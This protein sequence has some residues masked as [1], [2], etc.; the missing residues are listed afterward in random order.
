M[1]NVRRIWVWFWL[2][3]IVASLHVAEPH[4]GSPLAFLYAQHVAG[5]NLCILPKDD[6]STCC[7]YIKHE[8]DPHYF[9]IARYYYCWSKS[10]LTLVRLGISVAILSVLSV[11]LLSLSILVSNY[12]FVNIHE[13]TL[14]LGI[15]DNILSFILIPLTNTFPDLIN[16]YVILDSGSTELVLGQ[17]LGSILIMF[18]VIFGLICIFNDQYQVHRRRVFMVDLL[19]V[20]F[21]LMVFLYILSDSQ[22]TVFECSFM[23]VGY[24]VYVGF[25]NR[26]SKP[27]VAPELE[28]VVSPPL[29]PYTFE[30][31]LSI[32]SQEE[33][34]YGAISPLS[35]DSVPKI[36]SR[37][38]SPSVKSFDDIVIEE[39]LSI[40]QTLVTCI[41][42]VFFFLVPIHMTPSNLEE[43]EWRN[44]LN[45]HSL[46]TLW[47]STTIPLLINY[48]FAHLP[49]IDMIP[50]T[51]TIILAVFV[52]AP[53]LSHK[54]MVINVMGLFCSMIVLQEISLI[55]LQ[56]LK[57]FGLVWNMSDYLLGMLIF[58]VSNSI[59]DTITNLTIATKINPILGINACLG[60]PILL[61]FLG[62]G[63]NGFVVTLKHNA[64]LKFDLNLDLIVN[65]G[66][67]LVIL[68][69]YSIYV[70]L[71]KW[72]FD[73]RLGFLGI[74]WYVV[75]TAITCYLGS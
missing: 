43:Y 74:F 42:I 67:L 6:T 72:K 14:T 56:I 16:Y 51:A 3:A 53:Y 1:P 4:S 50:I 11:I 63:V 34:T 20:F 24:I 7:D 29:E 58:S 39:S 68:V 5:D 48:K 73:K 23:I 8:C 33:R 13:L 2:F 15:N 32:F 21:V 28:I 44:K 47:F 70:P 19:W 66:A 65:T 38:P 26:Y 49:W 10:P 9:M 25:L 46:L 52:A 17:L 61:V 40:T 60:T 54:A 12:L 57:N 75:I 36:V 64:P 41:N 71:N 37:S 62:I 59:N 45:N 55:I 27:V 31:A 30:D 69:L 22:I 35:T 18:T